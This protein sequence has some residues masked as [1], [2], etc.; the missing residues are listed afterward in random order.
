M[1]QLQTFKVLGLASGSELDGV[2]AAVITTDGIDV[3]NQGEYF[4]FPFDENLHDTLFNAHKN[5]E[6]LL[7]AERNNVEEKFNEFCIHAINEVINEVNDINLIGLGGHIIC[8]KPQEH[9]LCQIGNLHKI[10]AA[11]NIKTVGNFRNADILSGGLG[12]PLAAIYHSALSQQLEKPLVWVDVGGVSALTY[13]GCNGELRAFDTGAGNTV[14]NDWVNKH[15]GM[16][17]DYNGKLAICGKINE[18]ILGC[19]MRH[20]FLNLTPPKV[21]DKNTFVEKMEHLE[22]LNLED[23]AATATAFVAQSIIKAINDFIPEKPQKIIICGGGA[24]NPTLMRFIR[25]RA[26]G[27][28]V[29]TADDYGFRAEAIEAQAFAFLAVRR[30][31]QMPISYPFTTGAAMEVIGGEISE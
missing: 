27:I 20:K 31:N 21:A 16:H 24:K 2:R 15:G 17:C 30:C 9:I 3:F 4:D 12:A 7:D 26:E 18:E 29:C 5:N 11:I 19:L 10:A 22:G 8:H 14:I 28:T 6:T 1:S 25:Q 23:G 13:I